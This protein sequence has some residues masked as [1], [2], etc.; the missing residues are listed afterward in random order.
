[1]QRQP[2]R[3]RRRKWRLRMR[4]HWKRRHRKRRC[5]RLRHRTRLPANRRPC[6]RPSRWTAAA[7]DVADT[8]VDAVV[9]EDND[10]VA[11]ED[12]DAVAATDSLTSADGQNPSEEAGHRPRSETARNEEVEAESSCSRLK[13]MIGARKV[14]ADETRARITG[15]DDNRLDPS[16]VFFLSGT[17]AS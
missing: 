12:V 9:E 16:F 4:R 7:T 3:R 5:W 6:L 17:P 13:V 10:A 1:M 11:D 15:T 14:I 2:Q 8:T